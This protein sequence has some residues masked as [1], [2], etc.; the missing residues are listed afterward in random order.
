MTQ[1]SS[2][3]EADKGNG[4]GQEEKIKTNSKSLADAN[5]LFEVRKRIEMLNKF[6]FNL[7][8]RNNIQTSI[9]S[10]L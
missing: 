3:L 4:V 9:I 1:T 10:A 8:K 5:L 2:T 7:G 6:Q